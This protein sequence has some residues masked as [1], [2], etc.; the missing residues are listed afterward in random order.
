MKCIGSR[1]SVVSLMLSAILFTV[2]LSAKAQLRDYRSLQ[3]VELHGP[4]DLEHALSAIRKEHATA[5]SALRNAVTN[6]YRS[7]IV[8]FAAKSKLPAMY[9]DRE[10][11]EIG[12][13]MFYGPKFADF[14][15]APR[16]TW[17]KSS[18]EPNL[19]TC[20]SSSRPS[21]SWRSM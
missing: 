17:T 5:L 14:F 21:S 8:D 19:L 6:N 20:Q 9:P 3:P 16:L 1:W 11:V 12:G 2:C 18:R 10:F 4:G 13:F 7:R 15:R